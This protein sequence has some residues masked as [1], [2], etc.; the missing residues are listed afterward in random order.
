MR[1]TIVAVA[2]LLAAIPL[3]TACSSGGALPWVPVTDSPTG[4]PTTQSAPPV[5]RPDA[6]IALPS[7]AEAL[8]AASPYLPSTV[9][10]AVGQR[11]GVPGSLVSMTA[12]T[13]ELT[14]AGD[15]AVLRQDSDFISD[16]C[17]ADRVGCDAGGGQ[18]F[19]ALA[20]GTTTLT[21]TLH[22]RGKC[23]DAPTHPAPGCDS[24]TKSIQVTVR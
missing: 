23:P 1:R 10:L 19:I 12:V 14:S 11:L 8:K 3:L 18:T 20:P 16:P 22:E 9:T 24:V 17:P 15:G 7:R 4:P 21:W 2:A 13:W 5:S 6:E